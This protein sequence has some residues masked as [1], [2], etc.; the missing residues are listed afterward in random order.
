MIRF[1]L[2]VLLAVAFAAPVA[3]QSTLGVAFGGGGWNG[4]TIPAGQQ[5]RIH[6][7]RGATP[8]L[9]VSRIPAGTDRITVEFNDRDFGPLSSGGGHGI[10]GFAH[11]G[12]AMAT[13]RSVPGN[14]DRMPAGVT[15]VQAARSVGRFASLGYLPPCSGGRGH[16]Y[17]AIVRAMRGDTVLGQAEIVLGRY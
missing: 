6:E 5:C 10:I 1:A 13:L 15:V 9:R 3:A 17:F 4:Q 12:G 11:A 14:T 2:F 8:S 7:G 16:T